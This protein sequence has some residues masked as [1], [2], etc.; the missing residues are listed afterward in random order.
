MVILRL[1]KVPMTTKLAG[2]GGSKALV[3]GP[4]VYKFFL[5]LPL[6]EKMKIYIYSSIICLIIIASMQHY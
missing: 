2:G 1:K 4:I 3:V 6:V 5:R